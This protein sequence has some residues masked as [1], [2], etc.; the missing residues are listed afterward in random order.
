VDNTNS[1]DGAYS[2][3]GICNFQAAVCMFIA[4]AMDRH[5]RI[6]KQES[7]TPALLE[8]EK[9][10]EYPGRIIITFPASNKAHDN[11]TL[12]LPS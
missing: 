7:T 10:E 12:L 4:Y 3:A 6:K 8:P 11:G 9:Q 5:A 2:F 1:F